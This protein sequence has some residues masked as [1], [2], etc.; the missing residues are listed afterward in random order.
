MVKV[1][2]L[3]LLVDLG[4]KILA[5]RFYLLV[6]VHYMLTLTFWHFHFVLFLIGCLK[7]LSWLLEAIK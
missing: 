1:E 3:V 5:Q 6:E 4:G 2:A 7:R